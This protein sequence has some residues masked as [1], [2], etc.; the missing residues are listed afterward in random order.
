[1]PDKCLLSLLFLPLFLLFPATGGLAAS[2]QARAQAQQLDKMTV[3]DSMEST[4]QDLR[5]DSLDNPYRVEASARFGTEILSA[6]DIEN[7][8]PS[9]V[10]DLLNKTIGMNLTYQ[11]RESPFFIDQRGGG[12]F[13]YIIDGA[14]LPSTA[15]RVLYKFPVSA[16]EQLQVVRGA[17]SLTLGPSINIGAANSGS[18]LNTGFIIIRTKQPQKTQAILSGSVEKFKG[19]HPAASSE[20]VYLGIHIGEDENRPSGYLGWMLNNMDRPSKSSWFDGRSGTGGMVNSGMEAGKMRLNLMF[21][22]D[23]GDFEMQRGRTVDG[24]LSD[25]KWYY[26]PLKIRIFSGDMAINWSSQQVTLLNLYRVEY[27]QTEHNDSF[28]TSATNTKEYQEATNGIGLRHNLQWH[29]TLLQ[30]GGQLSSSKGSGP[31]LSYS[32]NKFDTT[33][34]GWSAS[35]EQKFLADDLVFN[36]GYRRDVKHIDN[37]SSAR[38]QTQYE[39]N[40]NANNDVDMAPAN[41]YAGG[42]HWQLTDTYALDGRYYYGDQGTSGDF[43]ML[44]ESGENLHGEKQQR[45]EVALTANWISW[46]R[47]TVTWFDIDIKNAKT[48]TSNTYETSSGTYYYYTES[49]ELRR[50]IELLIQGNL[51]R[52]TTYKLSWTRVLDNKSTSDGSTTDKNGVSNPENLYG[53]TLAHQWW[54]YRFNLAAKKV[55]GWAE[56]S[57]PMGTASWGG[58]GDYI[59]VDANIKRDFNIDGK[60]LCATLYGRNL[61]D[62]HYSTRYVTGYYPDRGMTVGLGLTM[63]F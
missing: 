9:D 42:M 27:D 39:Q 50:G 20:S 58:L 53:L 62:K 45:I 60:L 12:S 15:N 51:G 7:L 17:T 49:D 35:V 25:V 61:G 41:V 2:D 3:V 38:N 5:I 37:S 43:D 54:R 22:M 8:N 31:N 29:D 36:L 57:S 46:L 26:D 48:A 6:Q 59:R 1:M 14:V 44:T 16:I 19:G 34:I 21:Y 32:Y 11:G 47:P 55:D 18:D 56:S 23:S 24:M 30:F 63:K 28:A 13:T 10:Y 4:R 40:L 33:V 52:D